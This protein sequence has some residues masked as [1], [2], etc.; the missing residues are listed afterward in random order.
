MQP[1]AERMLPC[2]AGKV[3]HNSAPGSQSHCLLDCTT[4]SVVIWCQ[5]RYTRDLYQLITSGHQAHNRAAA[6]SDQILSRTVHV[7]RDVF[8]IVR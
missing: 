2:L 8:V 6:S 1:S 7:L 5:E 3:Y 4:N